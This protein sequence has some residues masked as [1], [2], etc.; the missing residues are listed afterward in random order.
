MKSVSVSRP[1]GRS[2]GDLQGMI[3]ETYE[4]LKGEAMTDHEKQ[5][6][7]MQ[8]ERNAQVRAI[9]SEE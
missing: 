5:Q 8:L 1:H 2:I 6:V 4:R 9:Y 7:R 3:V